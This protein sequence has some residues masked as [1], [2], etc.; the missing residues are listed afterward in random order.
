MFICFALGLAE[1]NISL[2]KS[3]AFEAVFTGE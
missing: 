2:I 3:G 1:F